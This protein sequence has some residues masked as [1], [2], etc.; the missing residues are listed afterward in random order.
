MH[1]I[2]VLVLG[3]LFSVGAALPTEFEGQSHDEAIA[4]LERAFERIDAD[5]TIGAGLAEAIRAQGRVDVQ[6][7][8]DP[9]GEPP[10]WVAEVIANGGPPSWVAEVEAEGG[11]PSWVSALTGGAELGGGPGTAGR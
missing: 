4:A 8:V 2:A 3:A 7:E 10:A 9:E 11:P 1:A 6:P 5:A